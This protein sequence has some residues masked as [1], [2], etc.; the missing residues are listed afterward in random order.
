MTSLTKCAVFGLL[1][2]FLGASFA[3]GPAV[4]L[5]IHH[6]GLAN[7]VIREFSLSLII[8]SLLLNIWFLCARTVW[9]DRNRSQATC[10]V[11][12]SY[13]FTAVFACIFYLIMS[14]F[15]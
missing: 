11:V 14:A 9:C 8:V 2:A 5:F 12:C 13:A 1:L 10:C 6:G 7:T 4:L 15:V 3:A